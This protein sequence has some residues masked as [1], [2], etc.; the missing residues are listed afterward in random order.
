MRNLFI[1][2]IFTI[3]S[4]RIL[5]TIQVEDEIKRQLFSIAAELQSKKGKKTSL[6]EAIKHLISI[7]LSRKR[8]VRRMLSL[9]GCLG[10]EPKARKLLKELRVEEEERLEKLTRKHLA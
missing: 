9:F 4:V 1:F 3:K 5:S 10:S 8:D 7:Y 2:S 6:N